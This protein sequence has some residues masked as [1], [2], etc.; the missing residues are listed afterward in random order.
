MSAAILFTVPAVGSVLLSSIFLPQYISVGASGGIFGL[1]GAAIAD[2]ARNR[3][4]LFSDFINKGRSKRHHALVVVIVF[5]DIILNLLIGLTPFTDNFMHIGG[6]LLGI[7]CA[8]TMLNGI[9]LFGMNFYR[10]KGFI[11]SLRNLISSKYFGLFISVLCM[12]VAT[13]A[14]FKGDGTTSPCESCGVLSCVSFPPWTNYDSRWWYCDSCGDVK[15]IGMI[16]EVTLEYYAIEI[17]CPD[18]E[19]VILNL[20]D[21]IDKSYEALEKNLPMF[22]RTECLNK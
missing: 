20:G 10:R 15:A 4:L 2:L 7:L 21:D 12:S 16:D 1:I 8:S 14:L 9:N 22:C 3:R 18:G 17:Q 5:L 19:D 11:P 13:I 6:F